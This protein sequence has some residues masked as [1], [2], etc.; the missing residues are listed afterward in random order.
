MED[1]EQ[2]LLDKTLI[3]YGSPMADANLHNHRRCP[4]MLLGGATACSRPPKG[5][6]HLKAP[7]ARRWPT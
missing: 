7:T 1:G 4:L 3:V 5:N 6:L 2:S